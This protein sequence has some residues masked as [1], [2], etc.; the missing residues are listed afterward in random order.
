MHPKTIDKFYRIVYSHRSLTAGRTFFLSPWCMAD[1]ILYINQFASLRSGSMKAIMLAALVGFAASPAIAVV[2]ANEDFEDDMARTYNADPNIFY[3]G[4]DG[5]P[6]NQGMPGRWIP[7]QYVVNDPW[8][9]ENDSNPDTNW[10]LQVVKDLFPGTGNSAFFQ[11][12]HN[13]LNIPCPDFMLCSRG[14]DIDCPGAG[15][16]PAP[17]NNDRY[18]RDGFLQ[19][20]T[21]D[22]NANGGNGAHVPRPAV[23]GDVLRIAYDVRIFDGFNSFALTNDIEKMAAETGDTDIHPPPTKWGVQFGQPSNPVP[24]GLAR[25]D[26]AGSDPSH[27]N[28]ASLISFQ[29][30]NGEFFDT[31]SPGCNRFQLDPDLNVSIEEQPIF[32]QHVAPAEFMNRLELTL[33]LT[34]GVQFFDEVMVTYMKPDGTVV[35]EEV[36]QEDP[37]ADRET[38]ACGGDPR[39]GE[40][41]L[42]P[43]TRAEILDSTLES[44][45]PAQID[46]LIFSDTRS[47][48]N[49]YR[50]DN[51]CIVINGDFSECDGPSSL[52]GDANNDLQVTG[53]DLIVVQ[54][55]FGKTYTNGACDGQ[56]LGDAN[57]DCLVTGA[58]LI[59][60]QQNFGKTAGPL[61]LPE[62]TTVATLV[63]LSALLGRKRAHRRAT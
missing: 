16:N 53:Q 31:W 10:Q 22:P 4:L 40:D 23:I 3:P 42:V 1:G 12:Q 51:I 54:Q 20:A 48:S 7:N 15:G 38:S 57:D 55:N 41:N 18:A 29:T 35:T 26:C 45:G 62:P 5:P 32:P 24:A 2:V 60:V 50:I 28:V 33:T 8:H 39:C 13:G 43:L 47:G 37:L 14:G 56:G 61:T 36:R 21:W 30:H 34:D 6:T 11:N 27:E 25:S 58:D 46:G 44:V 17:C 9:D 49:E 63:V 52:L 59:S 19:F